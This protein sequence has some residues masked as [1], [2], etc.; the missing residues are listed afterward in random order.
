MTICMLEPIVNAMLPLAQGFLVALQMPFIV[1]RTLTVDTPVHNC[2]ISQSYRSIGYCVIVAIDTTSNPSCYTGCN[3][4]VLDGENN[5]N[6]LYKYILYCR[7]Y[8]GMPILQCLMVMQEWRQRRMLNVIY[9]ATSYGIRYSPKTL[10]RLSVKGSS[11]QI[12]IF[13]PKPRKKYVCS[14]LALFISI[15]TYL[16]CCLLFAESA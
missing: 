14:R 10:P 7:G 1:M 11:Q 16:L 6:F 15:N 3:S 4:I 13:V 9:S 5:C 8:Q 2:K 12:K